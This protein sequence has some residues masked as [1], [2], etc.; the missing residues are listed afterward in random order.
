MES[1]SMRGSSAN[2][3]R[4]DLIRELEDIANRLRTEF[5]EMPQ[6]TPQPAGLSSLAWAGIE[7]S[8]PPYQALREARR[9]KWVHEHNA[10]KLVRLTHTM[11]VVMARFVANR[12]NEDKKWSVTAMETSTSF[13]FWM[14]ESFK[15]SPDLPIPQIP[16]DFS[17][18]A[19]EVREC[20]RYLKERN[21]EDYSR[22]NGVDDAHPNINFVLSGE[23]IAPPRRWE[24]VIAQEMRTNMENVMGDKPQG[25]KRAVDKVSGWF[26]ESG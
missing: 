4:K 3:E 14:S 22:W 5:L 2:G 6:E 16:E 23:D 26:E 1:H 10:R 13:R 21:H 17:F 9:R 18:T 25:W 20:Y 8:Q 24:D 11:I 19:K 12:E 15:H 7:I